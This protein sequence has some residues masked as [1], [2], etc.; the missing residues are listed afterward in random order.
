M[1]SQT[2]IL[3]LG[4]KASDVEQ[5]ITQTNTG[6]YLYYD[7]VDAVKS[8]ILLYF[9]AYKTNSLISHPI[10]LEQYSRKALTKT[11]SQLL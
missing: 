3:A 10:G 6:C 8:Q 7:D 4:P 5:L 11:L 2:P 1:V 9:N